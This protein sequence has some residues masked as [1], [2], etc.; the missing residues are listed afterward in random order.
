MFFLTVAIIIGCLGVM[1]T[2]DPIALKEMYQSP[3]D[4]LT[5]LVELL[6]LLAFYSYAFDK[7]YFS[8]PM[9]YVLMILV[10]VIGIIPEIIELKDS[11]MYMSSMF[12]FNSIILMVLIYGGVTYILVKLLH[13]NKI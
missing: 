5:S 13:R 1:S 6:Y 11:F 7:K 12:I 8:K 3:F 4:W 9:L 2:S 10:P